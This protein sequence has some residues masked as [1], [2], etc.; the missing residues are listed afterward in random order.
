MTRVV[1]FFL[2]IRKK[3]V[4]WIVII[5]TLELQAPIEMNWNRLCP[6]VRLPIDVCIIGKLLPLPTKDILCFYVSQ[7]IYMCVC[8]CSEC[9]EWIR[10]NIIAG[11]AAQCPTGKDKS[12]QENAR[13]V[14]YYVHVCKRSP[15][16]PCF[17]FLFFLFRFSLP[18]L[19][20]SICMYTCNAQAKTRWPG[21][22]AIP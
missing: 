1:S 9:D 17:F 16:S 5:H 8:V 21:D 18:L 12:R 11:R 22:Q 7:Y 6:P 13:H 15:P 20:L 3:S 4:F 19:S 10:H 2:S 14:Y